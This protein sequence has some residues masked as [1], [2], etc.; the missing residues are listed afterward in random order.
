MG[1]LKKFLIFLFFFYFLFSAFY[2]LEPASASK[3]DELRTYIGQKNQEMEAIQ[4]E[5][6]EYK[7]KIDITSKEA[8]SLKKQ[9]TILENNLA[10]IKA[11]ARYTQNRI[12]AANFTIEEL[13]LA[14]DN[15]KEKIN[16]NLKTLSETIRLIN[17]A[18]SNSLI[19]ILLAHKNLSEFF[20]NLDNIQNFEKDIGANLNELRDLKNV[21]GEQ[22]ENV[23]AEK[24]N[25]ESKKEELIDKQAIQ[26]NIQNQKESLFKQTKNKESLYKNLL[27]DRLK[28]QEALEKEIRAV[29]EELRVAIEP[30]YL[31]KAGAGILAWPMD[32]PIVITQYFGNT[33]FA[34]QNPQIYKGQGHKGI[35]LRASIG[36]PIKSSANGVVVDTGN[37]D[38]GCRGVSYGKWVLIEHPNNLSTMYSHLSLIKVKKGDIIKRGQTI[39]YSGDTGY[40][41][42]PHLD[43]QV[44]ASKAV[45]IGMIQSKICGTMM[46]LPLAPYNGY[47]NPL[48]YL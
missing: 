13:S 4:K 19:E 5:I 27:A 43:F 23:D 15:T 33:A 16:K 35:D 17:E 22:K 38:E 40:V 11:D 46:R 39:A 31:P 45:K 10:K 24:N 3:I 12:E 48:S 47:L 20:N 41:T 30:E 26:K 34:T 25:L 18:D 2:F 28:K 42:G 14:I 44:F 32:P 36:T 7:N 21:L 9:I 1:T 8:G 29:E 6:D 37:T